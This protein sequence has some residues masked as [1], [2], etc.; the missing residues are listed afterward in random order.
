M[1]FFLGSVRS[2]LPVLPASLPDMTRTLSPR[3]IFSATISA[4]LRHAPRRAPSKHLRG[5]RDDLHEVA[6]AQLARD[7]SEDAGPA[8]VSRV[9]DQHGGVLVEGD[10]GAVLAPE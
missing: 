5:E 6:L 2:T 10:V 9:V 8:R 7:G 3:R 4:S 1:R